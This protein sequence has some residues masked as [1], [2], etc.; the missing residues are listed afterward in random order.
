MP[1]ALD[2]NEFFIDAFHVSNK[3]VGK[4]DHRGDGQQ[5]R[6]HLQRIRLDFLNAVFDRYLLCC[7]C[8]PN[9]SCHN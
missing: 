3:L 9:I 8:L 2:I 1:I 7:L 6:V 4:F 5:C